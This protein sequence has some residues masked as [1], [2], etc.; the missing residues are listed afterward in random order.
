MRRQKGL[1]EEVQN[2]TVDFRFY[3]RLLETEE[4]TGVEYVHCTV[5]KIG[6]E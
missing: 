4:D 6:E 1:T 5:S 3:F 2:I